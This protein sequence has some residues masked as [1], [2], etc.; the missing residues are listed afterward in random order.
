[1]EFSVLPYG[2]HGLR[3]DDM[4]LQFFVLLDVRYGFCVRLDGDVHNIILMLL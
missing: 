4:S 2:R 3:G 1:M